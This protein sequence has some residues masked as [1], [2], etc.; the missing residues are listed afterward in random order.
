MVISAVACQACAA[1]WEE[2]KGL[3]QAAHLMLEHNLTRSA[4]TA[5]AV[6]SSLQLD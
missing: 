5:T 4:F 2:A 1:V 6:L 3:R